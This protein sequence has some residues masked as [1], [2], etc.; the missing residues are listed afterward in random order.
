MR[1]GPVGP[2]VGLRRRR[3]GRL[4]RRLQNVDRAAAAAE[5]ERRR[6]HAHAGLSTEPREIGGGIARAPEVV[7]ALVAA[8]AVAAADDFGR[9]A[10]ADDAPPHAASTRSVGGPWAEPSSRFARCRLAVDEI[11]V[12]ASFGDNPLWTRHFPVG[13]LAIGDGED[14][15]F[16][17]LATIVRVDRATLTR[18]RRVA[19]DVERVRLTVSLGLAEALA[20]APLAARID[21]SAAA[22]WTLSAIVHAALI[23]SFALLLPHVASDD[24]SRDQLLAMRAYLATAAEHDDAPIV[25]APAV[26]GPACITLPVAGGGGSRRD[27]REIGH[28]R[29]GAARRPA[30]KRAADALEDSA[31]FGVVALAAPST[32][33]DAG[34]APAAVGGSDAW[35]R[36]GLGNYGPPWSDLRDVV[37][38]EDVIGGPGGGGVGWGTI[39]LGPTPALG[40]VP[41]VPI[42]RCVRRVRVSAPRSIVHHPRTFAVA[43]GLGAA[44]V[45]VVVRRS[46]DDLARCDRAGAAGSVTVAF[47]VAR[48]GSVA[49]ARD[50]GSDL[51]D[52]AVRACVV[53]AFEKMVFAPPAGGTAT[54]TYA[55]A[56]AP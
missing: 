44:D 18:E 32:C 19:I 6:E 4:V 48:D 39:G 11:E 8:L 46:D 23:A 29:A 45:R 26:H 21:A 51:S 10:G 3:G 27:E 13:D 30:P 15:D 55:V 9:G 56:F 34:Y 2:R 20:R 37:P 12:T 35:P 38:S 36:L 40:V 33:D 52:A 50:A 22:S 1:R 25:P 49:A 31:A 7:E 42:G 41:A 43:G 24:V 54:V 17:G 5:D 28:A 16:P 14:C 47:L 53:G